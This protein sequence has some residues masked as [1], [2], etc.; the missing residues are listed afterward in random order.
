LSRRDVLDDVL[1][2]RQ[3]EAAVAVVV[4]M[5]WEAGERLEG[6]RINPRALDSLADRIK[7]LIPPDNSPDPESFVFQLADVVM[8]VYLAGLRTDGYLPNQFEFPSR[9]GRGIPTVFAVGCAALLANSC[10]HTMP[11][12]KIS[13]NEIHA[14]L[15]NQ[16]KGQL[17][18]IFQ[19]LLGISQR[20]N[21]RRQVIGPVPRAFIATPLTHLDEESHRVV[22]QLASEVRRILTRLGMAV[23]SPD[24][25]L[26]PATVSDGLPNELA[27]AERFLIT[28]SDLM[29][30]VGAE[31]E[32]WG[33]SRSVTW[34]E[35]CCSVV[36][37]TSTTPSFFSR[38][39][40]STPHRTYRQDAEEDPKALLQGLEKLL[41]RVYP[42]IESH[43]KDRLDMCDRV[44]PLLIKGRKQL[45]N[46]DY[47][48]FKRSLLTPERAGELLDHP[49]MLNHVSLA[50]M[51]EL[52]RLIGPIADALNDATLGRRMTRADPFMRARAGRELSAQS[53]SNLLSVARAEGW[54]YARIVRLIE[55][56]LSPT[57]PTDLVYH[58]DV[59][60]GSDWR[61][62][63]ERVFGSG[64]MV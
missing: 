48:A 57:L 28:G 58:N 36:I 26:T 55:E 45:L 64:D 44:R 20:L 61:R 21:V 13:Y 15:L 37:V 33:L 6:L 4:S 1:G 49:V 62:L 53:N 35:G 25:S 17:V 42:I 34:A 10:R 11:L 60:S 54:S 46:L 40:N 50:E 59:V 7:P 9:V 47:G 23:I 39:L 12:S 32:S 18:R 30:A 51:R 29:V 3:L 24:P 38:V 52:R 19:H 63:N 56:Y 43:A 41:E 16:D 22:L 31:H 8:T 5:Y 14:A 2:A 27:K